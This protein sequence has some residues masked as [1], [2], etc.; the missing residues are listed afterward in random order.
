MEAE[1]AV[2]EDVAKAAWYQRKNG[3]ATNEEDL[4]KYCTRAE[5]EASTRMS[6][7]T[8]YSPSNE[9]SSDSTATDVYEMHKASSSD[10]VESRPS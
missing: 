5:E 9:E 10:N 1:A 3:G 6:T 4:S 7:T 8:S 2:P